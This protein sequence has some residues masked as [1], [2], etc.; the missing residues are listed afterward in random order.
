ML[1]IVEIWKIQEATISILLHVAKSAIQNDKKNSIPC[2]IT[3]QLA[4]WIENQ[5]LLKRKPTM[6]RNLDTAMYKTVTGPY[7]PSTRNPNSQQGSIAWRKTTDYKPSR[8]AEIKTILSFKC[9]RIYDTVKIKYFGAVKLTR[10]ET[11]QNRCFLVVGECRLRF[12]ITLLAKYSKTGLPWRS[13]KK[14]P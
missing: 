10:N 9:P 3:T 2:T 12:R 6:L 11:E 1:T 14:F 7:C 13:R 4:I 8:I 5:E